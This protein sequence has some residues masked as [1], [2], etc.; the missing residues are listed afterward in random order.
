MSDCHLLLLASFKQQL[1]ANIKGMYY[2]LSLYLESFDCFRIAICK[3]KWV[4]AEAPSKLTILAWSKS[5]LTKNFVWYYC[6]DLERQN[7][8]KSIVW[9]KF[10][11][12]SREK[13][14]YGLQCIKMRFECEYTLITISFV[15]PDFFVLRTKD[16]ASQ[17]IM[18]I[19]F[20]KKIISLYHIS[21][22]K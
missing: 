16:S 10:W 19:F 12:D 17:K 11:E 4:A 6:R 22:H 15:H 21:S 9:E 2:I 1:S 18:P 5:S 8:A 14:K 13:K 20:W 3:L 7:I